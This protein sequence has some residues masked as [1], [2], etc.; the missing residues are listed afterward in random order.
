MTTVLTPGVGEDHPRSRGVYARRWRRLVR[1]NGSSP[2]AR[3]LRD[4]ASREIANPRIIPAR[5]GFTLRRVDAGD[6]CQDHPRSRGVY[7]DEVCVPACAG[8]IIPAR[9]GF[10][11]DSRRSA[12][13]QQDHPRSRGVY[14]MVWNAGCTTLGSSPLARGLP[15]HRRGPHHP[16]RIIPA[17]AGFTHH[18]RRR[19]AVR[20]DHPRSRGVY[21]RKIHRIATGRGSS[22]LAR[23]LPVLLRGERPMTRIIPARAGFTDAALRTLV[24]AE[25]GA[26]GS[27]PLAR[28][29]QR[30]KIMTAT[31]GSSPLARG[32]RHR[33]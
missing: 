6:S 29:L 1:A 16:R 14:P 2:L 19:R 17:R 21:A 8:R 32:L 30:E 28:G 26:E 23:G 13:A 18:R 31:I 15:A 27:S 11:P 24:R 25:T 7:E 4:G 5:A 3:G 12:S 22:P 20:T 10:T 9:A 33:E